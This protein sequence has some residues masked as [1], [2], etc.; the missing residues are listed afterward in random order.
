M[1]LEEIMEFK[2]DHYFDLS[3]FRYKD[4]FDNVDVVWDVLKRL[5]EY[6]QKNARLAIHPEAQIHP[7]AIVEGDVTI[8]KGTVVGEYAVIKGPTLIGENCQIQPHAHVRGKVIAGDYTRIGNYTEIVNAIL[9]GGT[10]PEKQEMAHFAHY[11]YVGYCVVGNR[12]ILG[13]RVRGS[14]NDTSTTLEEGVTTSSLRA[15]WKPVSVSLGDTKYNTGLPQF[16]AIIEDDV[17][18]GCHTVINPGSLIGKESWI[19]GAPSEWNGYLAP[20]RFAKGKI[21][22]YQIVDKKTSKIIF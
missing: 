11:N 19:S 6:L 14:D 7:T 21:T 3:N 20:K 12:V 22:H 17:L 4:V 5:T 15:D 8:G 9:L 1:K 13:A 2:T 10:G 16:S 18:I